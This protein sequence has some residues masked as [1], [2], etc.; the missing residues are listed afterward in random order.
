MID[1]KK[2]LSEEPAF[3]LEK[4]FL[5]KL[6]KPTENMARYLLPPDYPGFT[7][8]VNIIMPPADHLIMFWHDK[9]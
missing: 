3:D 9:R 5:L 8:V 4:L 2:I 7:F 6:D 1:K